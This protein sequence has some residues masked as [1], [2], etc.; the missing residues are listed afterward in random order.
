MKTHPL[1]SVRYDTSGKVMIALMG[2]WDTVEA[3]QIG[4]KIEATTPLPTHLNQL[5]NVKKL[6]HAVSLDDNRAFNYTPILATHKD[7]QLLPGQ[8]INTI[9]D[10]VWFNGSHKDVGGGH[11]KKQDL[12]HISLNWMLSRVD[13][14]RLFRDTCL[15]KDYSGKVH[16]MRKYYLRFT[17][18]GDTLR[19]IRTYWADMNP[20]W[21]RHRIRIHR[22]V[23][24]RLNEGRVQQ[25][26]TRRKKKHPVDWY[27]WPEFAHCFARDP[28][29]PKRRIFKEKECDCIEVTGDGPIQ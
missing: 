6:L 1:D 3:L 4:D 26:K 15:K 8:D 27:D 12:Q 22:S 29:H 25:F 10:E 16:N 28:A 21:N 14:Y 9:V 5:Y 7:V 20:S 23:V 19:S 2:L 18:P 17:S 24:E 11:K 13:S